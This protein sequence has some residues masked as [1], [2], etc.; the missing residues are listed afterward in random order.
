VREDRGDQRCACRRESG[1]HRWVSWK[2]ENFLVARGLAYGIGLCQAERMLNPV[3]PQAFQS[4][5][6]SMTRL[7]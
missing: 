3:A 2:K 5:L 6:I 1:T 4:W 7:N